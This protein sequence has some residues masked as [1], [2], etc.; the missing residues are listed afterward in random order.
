MLSIRDVAIDPKSLGDKMLL[1]DVLPVYEFINN[2]RGDK[3]VGYKYVVALP[4]HSFEKIAVKIVGDK[5]VESPDTFVEVDFTNLEV[6]PY[7]SQGVTM[8]GA[9]ATNI[10][11]I[12]SK[13]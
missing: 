12:N 13:N 11:I 10:K 7:N 4:K 9:R 8:I 6:F 5:L 1:T 3:V 2:Q